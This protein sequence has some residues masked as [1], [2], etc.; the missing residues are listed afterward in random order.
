MFKSFDHVKIS[1]VE[2]I[3][4]YKRFNKSMTLKNGP[5]WHAIDIYGNKVVIGERFMVL[6]PSVVY[7]GATLIKKPIYFAKTQGQKTKEFQRIPSKLLV[8]DINNGIILGTF[9]DKDGYEWTWDLIHMDIQGKGKKYKLKVF[10]KGG[11]W[12]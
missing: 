11:V 9:M 12:I 1:D 8:E 5:E 2:F 7:K 6:L 10:T 3:L 4:H